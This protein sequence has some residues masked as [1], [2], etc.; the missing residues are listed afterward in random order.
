V[1]VKEPNTRQKS[2]IGFGLNNHVYVSGNNTSD[3]GER[4]V[5]NCNNA[6]KLE[7]FCSSDRVVV[8]VDFHGQEIYVCNIYCDPKCDFRQS[9]NYKNCKS[10]AD[11][12]DTTSTTRRYKTSNVKW[13]HFQ[14]AAKNE[15]ERIA[16]QVKYVSSSETLNKVIEQLTENIIHLCDRHLPKKSQR[17]VKNYW[18]N[19]ELTIMRKR[20]LADY[21]RF[22]RCRCAQLRIQY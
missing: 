16:T 11:L 12:S 7:Q 4:R 1:C 8:C 2:V 3:G 15:L 14:S 20:A 13:Q 5:A 18:W 9:H 17:P 10:C 6:M 21:R 19:E 22:K